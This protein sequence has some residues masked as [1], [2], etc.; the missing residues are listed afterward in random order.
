MPLFDLLLWTPS[1]VTVWMNGQK[2]FPFSLLVEMGI[3]V[4]LKNLTGKSPAVEKGKGRVE[5]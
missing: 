2:G 5:S 1:E 4:I 3:P